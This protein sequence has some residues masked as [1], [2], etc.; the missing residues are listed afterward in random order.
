MTSS[1][2]PR[3]DFDALLGAESVPWQSFATLD[4][5]RRHTVGLLSSLVP[6]NGVAWNEV[7]VDHGRVEAVMEPDLVTDDRAAAFVSHMGDHPVIAT[8]FSLVTAG[9][10]P[11]RTSSTRGNSMP[12]ASI[13]TSTGIWGRRTRSPSSSPTPASSWGSRPTRG[14][15]GFSDRECYILNALRPHLVQAY[16][17]AEDPRLPT[18]PRRDGSAGRAR[19][20]RSEPPRPQWGP[21]ALDTAGLEESFAR[22][23]ERPSSGPLPETVCVHGCTTHTCRGPLRCLW[24]S[25]VTAA[26]PASKWC[27]CP[28]ATRCSCRR[29]TATRR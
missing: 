2:V 18:L 8:L 29:C 21:R 3:A 5:L 25:T 22:W 14:P 20:R 27:R 1:G 16:R 26:T 13:S 6:T 17:N 28:T 12:P 10:T 7:D 4:A 24:S 15:R 19:W 23:F 11:S 9:P